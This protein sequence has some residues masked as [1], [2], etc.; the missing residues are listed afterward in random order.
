MTGS[1]MATRANRHMFRLAAR[2]GRLRWDLWRTDHGR[3]AIV[4]GLVGLA[5]LILDVALFNLL[6]H[7]LDKPLTSKFL[8]SSVALVASYFMNRHWTWRDR[9]AT[10]EADARR[11]R[12]ALL[13]FSL[14]MVG[15]GIAEVC[16][17]VSHYGL[18][19]TS[20]WADNISAN[21]IGLGLAMIWRFW[22][23]NRWVFTA[24]TAPPPPLVVVDL[25]PVDLRDKAGEP[26][27]AADPA[28]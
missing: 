9:L 10:E 7:V 18:D 2:L 19:L 25:T 5:N 21:V 20:R 1:E 3:R 23:Y 12:E 16:L 27:L 8:A 13:F 11:G 15:V 22:S 4:F 26:V 28:S 17:L 24:P 14:S 6:L